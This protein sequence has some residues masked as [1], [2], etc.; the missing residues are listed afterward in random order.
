MAKLARYDQIIQHIFKAGYKGGGK[1]VAFTRD[2]IEDTCEK[3]RVKRP[4]NLRDVVYTFRYRKDLPVSITETQPVGKEWVIR[5]AGD[6]K[7]RFELLKEFRVLPNPN[8]GK[9]K[10]PDATPGVIIK[11]AQ[12]DE[13]A[14]LAVLRYNRLLDIFLG[15]ACYSLQSHL[16]TKVKEI[17][18]LEVDELYIAV[19]KSGAHYVVPVQAKTK[20]DKLGRIQIEQ[21]RAYAAFKHPN[22]PCRPVGAQFLDDNTVA[23]FEFGCEDG[24]IVQVDEKHYRLV[25]PQDL[26][27]AD[28]A[29]YAAAAE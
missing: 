22:L 5:P 14:L 25:A 9:I 1:S 18:Q 12:T 15:A 29:A 2:D 8:L 6:G 11:Y 19:R 17:G 26:S 27:D 24:D 10:I 7:Y 4:K 16:R 13:Q 21:D 3:L 20:K 23:L 28:L